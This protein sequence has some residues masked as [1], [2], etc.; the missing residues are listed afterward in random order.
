ME[1]ATR[2]P[3]DK[4]AKKAK[5]AVKPQLSP[6]VASKDAP[7][8]VVEPRFMVVTILNEN[9][10]QLVVGLLQRMGLRASV[11]NVDTLLGNL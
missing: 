7:A 4:K 2:T 11:L 1:M 10:T 3:K 9:D 5:S 8:P 6:K